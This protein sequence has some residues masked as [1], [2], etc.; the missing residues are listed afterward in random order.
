VHA[1]R[2]DR[3]RRPG[4]AAAEED[5]GP[6]RADELDG[7]APR[8]RRAGRLDD[9]V[10][11]APVL[12]I[13]AELR[14]DGAPLGAASDRDDVRSGVGGG[15]AEHEPCRAYAEDGDRLP[16]LDLRALDRVQAARE[17][18]D[19]RGDLGGQALGD[20]E[21]APRSDSLRDEHVLGV[22][23]V[24]ERLEPLAERL[25]AARAGRAFA[26]RSRVRSDDPSPGGDVDARKLMAERAG[27]LAEKERVAPT[28]RLRV[29]PAGERGLDGNEN[30][31]GTRLRARNVLETDI[32]GPVEAKRLHGVN[33]TLSASRRR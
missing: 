16:G 19:E 1:V 30:L 2:V 20:G 14:R 9:D 31:A 7:V 25:G 10:R 23:A 29:G 32:A 13:G 21:E 3:D 4:R 6:A 5:D 17:R 22:R 28:E 15:G 11:A 33:T 24:Q 12:E 8:F 26:A 18:L 27:K